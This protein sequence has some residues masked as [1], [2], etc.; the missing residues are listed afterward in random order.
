MYVYRAKLERVIDGDTLEVVIDLGFNI[1][2][3]IKVRLKD[4]DTPEIFRP[5]CDKEK[6]HG[7]KAKQFVEDFIEK[8]AYPG[9]MIIKTVRDTGIYGRYTAV[10]YRYTGGFDVRNQVTLS[11]ALKEHGFEKKELY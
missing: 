5:S 9:Q 6:K 3:K 7:E 4:I 2:R 8:N 10:V 11:E 1:F